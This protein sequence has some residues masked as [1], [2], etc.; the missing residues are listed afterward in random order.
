MLL[1]QHLIHRYH[2]QPCKRSPVPVTPIRTVGRGMALNNKYGIQ[3][4]ANLTSHLT[5]TSYFK[6]HTQSR[7]TAS[8]LDSAQR[9]SL[10]LGI[11]THTHATS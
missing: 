3:F 6:E 2:L 11:A 7:Y 8:D 4:D 9:T 5:C 10:P 1:R